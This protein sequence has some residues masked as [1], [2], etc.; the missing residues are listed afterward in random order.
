MHDHEVPCLPSRQ[1]WHE[2]RITHLDEQPRRVD[3]LRVRPPDIPQ[4]SAEGHAEVEPAGHSEL[5]HHRD[6]R[7]SSGHHRGIETD[8]GAEA[9]ADD[10]HARPRR[11]RHRRDSI[12]CALEDEPGQL[13]AIARSIECKCRGDERV[14]R[15]D[16]C[17]VASRQVFERLGHRVVEVADPCR[18]ADA[19][20]AA[21]EGSAVD[22]VLHRESGSLGDIGRRLVAANHPNRAHRRL[23]RDSGDLLGR[24]CHEDEATPL[25]AHR[26]KGHGAAWTRRHIR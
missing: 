4:L 5:G 9:F 3:G 12:P 6:A 19:D 15:H 18:H 24:E 13:L 25:L 8:V 17:A 1:R 21:P 7:S 22:H 11:H 26:R 2:G 23:A 10:E 20:G 14:L 16:R